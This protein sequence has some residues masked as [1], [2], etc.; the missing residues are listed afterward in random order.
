MGIIL[1]IEGLDGGTLGT[2]TS[3]STDQ[4]FSQ[5]ADCWVINKVTNENMM[6]MVSVEQPLALPRPAYDIKPHNSL[7]TKAIYLLILCLPP[8]Y[9]VP[10]SPNPVTPIKCVPHRRPFHTTAPTKDNHK[11]HTNMSKFYYTTTLIKVDISS[12]L[13]G[14]REVFLEIIK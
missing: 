7:S 10:F 11:N 12:T 6:V 2:A 8:P 5:I 14:Q 9:P 4:P 3:T 1:F 13:C